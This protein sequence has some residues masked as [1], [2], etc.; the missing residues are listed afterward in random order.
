M[1]KTAKK[2]IGEVEK[3]VDGIFR[4][5]SDGEEQ[6]R[7]NQPR[8]RKTTVPEEEEGE[9]R[10]SPTKPPRGQYSQGGDGTPP[11]RRYRYH[12]QQYDPLIK[13]V[14]QRM[15]RETRKNPDQIRYEL[16]TQMK[17]LPKSIAAAVLD[18]LKAD[19]LGEG[20]DPDPQTDIQT[21][22]KDRIKRQLDQLEMPKERMTQGMKERLDAIERD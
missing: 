21:P 4:N 22:I 7:E 10:V 12:Y 14:T 9:E 1:G 5:I 3:D 20:Q 18:D 13:D 15:S 16:E 11:R 17:G 19:L 6:A 2:V 8:T